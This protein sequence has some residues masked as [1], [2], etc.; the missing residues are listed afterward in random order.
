MPELFEVRIVQLISWNIQ[1]VR[2]NVNER[3]VKG[4]IESAVVVLLRHILKKKAQN[5][6]QQINR[7]FLID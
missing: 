3:R 7:G 4:E 5:I 1:S 2:V 6:F